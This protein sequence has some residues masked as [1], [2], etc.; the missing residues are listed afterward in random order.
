MYMTRGR[1]R[2][3]NHIEALPEGRD[4]D[5]EEALC[6]SRSD[7]TSLR[8]VTQGLEEP[9]ATALCI[10]PKRIEISAAS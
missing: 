5:I 4:E 7:I 1:I 8:Q 3:F 6:I 2:M 10:H 9:R